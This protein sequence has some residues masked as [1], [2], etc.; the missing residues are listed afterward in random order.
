MCEE[1]YLIRMNISLPHGFSALLKLFLKESSTT[2]SDKVRRAERCYD[3][4]SKTVKRA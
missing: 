4:T 3:N 2:T 1:Q